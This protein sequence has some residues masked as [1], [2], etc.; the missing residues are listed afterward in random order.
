MRFFSILVLGLATL[1]I[2]LLVSSAQGAQASKAPQGIVTGTATDALGRPL[3]GANVELQNSAGK[4]VARTKS[5]DEGRF[6]FAGVAPGVYAVVATKLSFKPATSIVSVAASGAKRLTLAL[7]SQTALS[8]QVA[9]T[10]INPQPNAIS[11]TGT[12]Q[13][14]LTEHNIASLPQGVNTPIN[15]VLL[16]MPGVVQDDEAQVHVDGEHEDLQWR[17][18]GVM[19]P[20]DSFTGFGQIFNSFFVKRVSLLDGILPVTYGYRDAGVLDMVTK[21]GCSNPGG[22]VGFYGGQRET[23]QP[24]FNMADVRDR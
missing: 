18:N 23:Q 15:E 5:D 7:Q 12:S 14:T 10:R 6:T 20:M 9:T 4:V 11:E 24:S 1:L 22:N 21:D 17:V 19:M 8:L 16:Q 13:Y 2:Q 3:K